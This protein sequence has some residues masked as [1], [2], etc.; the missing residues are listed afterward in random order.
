[1]MFLLLLYL[2]VS[3]TYNLESSEDLRTML[4]FTISMFVSNY[5][6]A[7]NFNLLQVSQ[8][9]DSECEYSLG[10]KF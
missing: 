3:A 1:M 10:R 5:D 9:T 6:T 2:A 4:L 7:N 8:H